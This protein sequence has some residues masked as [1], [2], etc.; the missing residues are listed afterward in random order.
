M[1][2]PAS[3]ARLGLNTHDVEKNLRD[4]M[5][6][7][8]DEEELY[9]IFK[10]SPLLTEIA[11]LIV[12][13]KTG[14]SV[15]ELANKLHKK[16]ATVHKALR[17]LRTMPFVSTTYEGKRKLYQISPK[18]RHHVE[19]ILVKLYHPTKR[20]V[21]GELSRTEGLNVRVLHNTNVRGKC[22]THNFDI[23]YVYLPGILAGVE[24]PRYIGLI[25]LEQLTDYDILA[26]GGMLVDLQEGGEI[27]DAKDDLWL[28]AVCLVVVEDGRA[29]SKSFNDLDHFL[30]LL[31]EM[32]MEE[33]E[34]L[35]DIKIAAKLVERKAPQKGIEEVRVW[36]A[37]VLF[38]R[39]GYVAESDFVANHNRKK[40]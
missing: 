34:P 3:G 36:A 17:R 39:E 20:F 7:T 11:N 32:K 14:L 8:A 22:F 10:T 2:C 30:G 24:Q 6:R 37:S 38:E 4:A 33:G 23:Q 40:R 21:I 26:L 13:S 25:V 35:L 16:E 31:R 12:E 18:N 15:G 1:L 28:V 19:R 29:T 5:S 27:L 9:S